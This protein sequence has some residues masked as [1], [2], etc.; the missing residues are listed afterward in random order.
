MIAITTFLGAA[1]RRLRGR[2]AAGAW[3]TVG[4]ALSAGLLVPLVMS[5]P[6]FSPPFVIGGYGVLLLLA[7]LAAGVGAW[8][9]R[10]ATR[11]DSAVAR[12]LPLRLGLADDLR[13]ALE[14]GRDLPTLD[15]SQVSRGLVLALIADV[16]RELGTLDLTALVPMHAI[17][18]R[19]R[20][21]VSA[22]V[23][24]GALAAWTAGARWRAGWARLYGIETASAAQPLL[25][26]LRVTLSYPAYT[27]LPPRVLVDT[28]GDFAALP[29]TRVQRSTG[30]CWCRRRRPS[31]SSPS[32]A[33]EK[34]RRCPRR[35]RVIRLHA[36]IDITDAFNWQLQ[37]TKGRRRLLDSA[38][39][40]V[41]LQT[42][43]APHIDL[44]VPAEPLS[45]DERRPVELGWVADDDYGLGRIDL[46]WQ[47]EGASQPERQ[48]LFAAT[49]QKAT[50]SEPDDNRKREGRYVWDI[51]TIEL[52]SA[53]Q[54]ARAT[55][56]PSTSTMRAAPT[57][58]AL[59]SSPHLAQRAA[60][61][62]RGAG[63][64]AAP[65]R[66]AGRSAGRAR[67]TISARQHYA[68]GR[69]GHGGAAGGGA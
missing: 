31:C 45:L 18:R 30:S 41:T 10:W 54:A 60:A 57:S 38:V 51:G 69:P 55:S 29:G 8:R 25:G 7:T 67:P 62:R 39:H 66:R 23:V 40:H 19:A 14:L 20:R 15:A 53:S 68:A 33:Q 27:H 56:K 44:F 48:T 28:S 61:A 21:W 49:Q 1:R 9:E 13:S 26:D 24:G 36:A 50:S 12:A 58:A 32:R 35:C 64:R 42:D 5:V 22:V 34:L 16:S 65:P 6:L 52:G 2:A 43:R 37:V 4:G 47:V 11:S 3:L 46:V 59:A 17:R 63:L